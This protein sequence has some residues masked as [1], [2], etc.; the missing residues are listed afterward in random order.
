[1]G[2]ATT[3]S[4]LERTLEV[5]KKFFKGSTF[6]NQQEYAKARNEFLEAIDMDSSIPKIHNALGR[7]YFAEKKIELAV[8]EYR[9]ALKLNK[10]FFEAYVNLGVLYI[11]KRNWSEAINTFEKLLEFPA[12]YPD[13]FAYNYL[14][15]IYSEKEDYEMAFQTLRKAITSNPTY[16]PAR[17]NMGL[18]LFSLGYENKAI[19]EFQKATALNPHFSQARHQLGLVYM[20][21]KMFEEALP[22]FRSVI[23][24][25]KDEKLKE[26]AREFVKIIEDIQKESAE[27]GKQ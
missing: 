2:C 10:L 8:Q 20:K 11:A 22:E 15:W 27:K 25:S 4:E 26:A 24:I 17:Y 6:L 14:G 21:K 7:A 23:K 1:M 13:Y 12:Q 18:T 19:Q 5:E 9:T 3:E 16:A